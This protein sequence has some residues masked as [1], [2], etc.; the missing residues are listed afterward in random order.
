MINKYEQE[1]IK[2]STQVPVNQGIVKKYGSSNF[3]LYLIS[4]LHCGSMDCN[5]PLLKGAIQTIKK[6]KRALVIVGGDTIEGIPRGYKINEEGQHCPINTQ[7]AMTIKELK[8]IASKILVLF[9]GNH[10]THSRGESVDSDFVIANSL[11]VP[12]KTVPTI[13]QIHTPLGTVKLAG[14]HGRSGAQNQDVELEKLRKIFP[15]ADAYFLGHTH[16]LFAKQMGALTYDKHGE[17]HWEPSWFIRT[18]NFINYA[19]YA[20]YAFY[21]PQRSGFIKL[22]VSKGII[23][24]GFA[25]T[26]SDILGETHGLKKEKK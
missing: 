16:A 12:Y 18:G 17:E 21:P 10:N 20:R 25:L 14:G 7:I 9:K 24:D 13:I 1:R 8:P 2:G 4:D 19:E 15:N 6:D 26:D 11:G 23:T 22:T 5:Y 3:N